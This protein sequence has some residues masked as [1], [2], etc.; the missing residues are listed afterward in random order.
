M[1]T[2][3]ET[4]K[5]FDYAGDDSDV[6]V[7][8]RVC[9]AR[10]LAGFP[11]AWKMRA[12]DRK[13]VLRT[14]L[15]AAQ[16]SRLAIAGQFSCRLL[17]E[18]SK[19]ELVSLAERGLA[20]P[21]FIARREG[22]ALLCTED[23]SLSVSVNGG[24]HLLLA[25]MRPGLDLDGAYSAVDTL[26]S[27]L[28]RA[29]DFAFDEEFGYLTEDPAD[30]GTG[31]HAELT[32]HL[33][34]LA[35]AGSLPRVAAGL[36]KLGL[37]LREGLG[38]EPQAEL[39]RLSNQVTLGISEQ[40]AVFNLKSMAYQVVTQERSA[41]SALCGTVEMQDRIFRAL[42]VLQNARILPL[43]EFMSCFSQVRL[44]VSQQLFEGIRLDGMAAL[45]AEAQPATLMLGADKA[46]SAAERDI[47]RA[48]LAR[49]VL[50]M[51]KEEG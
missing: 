15:E 6:I 16:S 39:Y 11:F 5:W 7:S 46:L 37:R 21:D 33:P 12:S 38:A 19:T 4:K 40:E 1:D 28:S 20:T 42:G 35:R 23:E 47:A 50:A 34:A 48:S 44:G 2:M 32:L 29:L 9:V 31:M 18:L 3:H 27:V 49:S 36:S 14:V 30:L 41:R 22:R 10:N 43:P 51:R 26:E 24:D 45:M 25:A 17:E 8:T 13:T